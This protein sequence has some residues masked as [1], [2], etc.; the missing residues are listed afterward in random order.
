MLVLL[1]EWLGKQKV[2]QR[3][4][5]GRELHVLARPFCLY[6]TQNGLVTYYVLFDVFA[7]S[8]KE[9][10]E[11]RAKLERKENKRSRK[12][13]STRGYCR[14]TAGNCGSPHPS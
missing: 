11:I 13:Q 12:L 2:K 4:S 10:G 6:R 14:L 1:K 8:G 3:L 7:V 9:T 5:Q